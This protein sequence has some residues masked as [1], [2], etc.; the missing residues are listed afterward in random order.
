MLYKSA[1][2]A[3]TDVAGR[4]VDLFF[5]SITSGLPLI[6]AKRVKP[7]AVTFRIRSLLLRDVPSLNELGKRDFDE[8]VVSGVVAPAGMPQP[9]LMG[10]NAEINKVLSSPAARQTLAGLGANRA[11]FGGAARFS[12]PTSGRSGRSEAR[13]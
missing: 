12:R 4:Q 9:A 11:F 10:L 3:M 8:N 5:A 6:N 1:A 7:L 2:P 13:W